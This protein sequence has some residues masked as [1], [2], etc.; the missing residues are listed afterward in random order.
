VDLDGDA[1]TWLDDLEGERSMECGWKCNGGVIVR[2]DSDVLTVKTRLKEDSHRC[3][4][5]YI[6]YVVKMHAAK[7]A[8]IDSLR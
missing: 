4:N 8:K 2:E 3:K 5:I 7:V 6:T 1:G